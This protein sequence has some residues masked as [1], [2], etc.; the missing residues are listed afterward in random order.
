MAKTFRVPVSDDVV[1]ALLATVYEDD[2]LYS[3]L[4]F[5]VSQLNHMVGITQTELDKNPL[6][7]LVVASMQKQWGKRGAGALRVGPDGQVYL[8]ILREAKAKKDTG[9]P[10]GKRRGRKPLPSLEDL[11][12]EAESLG[13]DPTPFGRK[14]TDILAAIQARRSSQNGAVP[15]EVKQEAPTRKGRKL[16]DIAANAEEEVDIDA[17][18][19]TPAPH[20]PA[21]D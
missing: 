5:A 2:T 13:L 6:T 11:R 3:A 7:P 18:L 21:E 10:A 15:V 4:V 1:A 12:A 17:I 9:K 14:K 16:T 19:S 20:I 8:E